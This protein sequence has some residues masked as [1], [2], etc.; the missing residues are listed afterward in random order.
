MTV[1]GLVFHC[2]K[3]SGGQ[4]A[5]I[6]AKLRQN[7]KL[8]FAP[9]NGSGPVAITKR[10]EIRKVNVR[11]D[12][13]YHDDLFLVFPYDGKF[14]S[15]A[16]SG[17]VRPPVERAFPQLPVQLPR[18]RLTQVVLPRP[19]PTTVRRGPEEQKVPLGRR[20]RLPAAACRQRCHSSRVLW[21]AL[22]NEKP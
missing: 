6:A 10:N 2:G 17:P 21:A 1:L 15:H 19:K 4:F 5:F 20:Q 9:G 8:S 12:S 7:Y 22:S 3:I 18:M 16:S 11:R 14:V 13:I